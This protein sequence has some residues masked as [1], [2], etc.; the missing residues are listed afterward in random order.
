MF[1][2][3]FM[4]VVFC[5]QVTG[6]SQMWMDSDGASFTVSSKLVASRTALDIN[7]NTE[8]VLTEVKRDDDCGR[9]TAADCNQSI[10]RHSVAATV[11]FTVN[12]SPAS[13]EFVPSGNSS[14]ETRP[15]L[16]PPKKRKI[17]LTLDE[18]TDQRIEA[19]QTAQFSE[20]SVPLPQADLTEW[21]GQRVLARNLTDFI[22]RPGLIKSISTSH[23]LIGIQFDGNREVIQT[24]ADNVISDN[25]P[26]SSAIIV[27]MRVCARTGSEQVE[28]RLGVVRDRI[29]QPPVTKF[30]IELDAPDSADVAS[31]TWLS[32]ASLRLLQ[33]LVDCFTAAVLTRNFK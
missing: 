20:V 30:L 1:M 13:S 14:C 24:A 23:G 33:V 28:Y 3:S 18:S 22:Y 15:I 21:K 4:S 19:C 32:R 10:L 31:P 26:P 17:N 5:L 25:A 29:L 12:C 2:F 16:R 9:G 8:H 7:R 27:G 6:L 11:A